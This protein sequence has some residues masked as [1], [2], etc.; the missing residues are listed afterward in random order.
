MPDTQPQAFVPVQPV[1]GYAGFTPAWS[2]PAPARRASWPIAFSLNGGLS[3]L[4]VVGGI[5]WILMVFN[6]L[7]A[8][9]TPIGTGRYVL[10]LGTIAVCIRRALQGRWLAVFV[11]GGTWLVCIGLIQARGGP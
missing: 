4:G 9:N 6:T 2:E 8:L 10:P 1:T 5:V 11:L 7:I 3:Q